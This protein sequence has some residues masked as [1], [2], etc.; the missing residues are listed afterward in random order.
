MEESFSSFSL[1]A[2]TQPAEQSGAQ[3]DEKP[4]IPSQLKRRCWSLTL[5]PPRAAPIQ[6]ERRGWS[7]KAQLAINA[8]SASTADDA[9]SRLQKNPRQ[10]APQSA[11]ASFPEPASNDPEEIAAGAI[12][13]YLMHAQS[14]CFQSFCALASCAKGQLVQLGQRFIVATAMPTL[15]VSLRHSDEYIHGPTAATLANLLD[16]TYADEVRTIIGTEGASRLLTLV[17]SPSQPVVREAARALIAFGLDHL[18]ADA[19]LHALFEKAESILL[20][21]RGAVADM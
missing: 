5:Y 14:G 7:E 3:A 13:Y 11:Y 16:S 2:T 9:L 21:H 17:Q 1:G 15:R 4:F 18:K 6:P 8:R 19:E 12:A 20:E 10:P